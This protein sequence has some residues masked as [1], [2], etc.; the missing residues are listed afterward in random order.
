M[1]SII[2]LKSTVRVE[3]K[4]FSKNL[5]EA[6]ISILREKYERKVDKD[7][8]IVL[9][10]WNP[11]DISEGKVIP[12][13]G[14]SYHE[15]TFDML[16]YK[17][18]LNEIFE[19]EVTEIVEFGVFVRMGPIDGLAHLSQ[20]TNDFLSYDKKI[21]AFIGRESKKIIKKGDDV[22]AKISTV[23]MK[24]SIPETKIGL[25]MRPEGLGKLDWIKEEA[26]PKKIKEEAAP[27]KK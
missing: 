14:A 6:I 20:I 21:P 5:K 4:Y 12:G 2:T 18:E 22:L 26:A 16:T 10:I 11:R 19:G 24:G 8:G 27:K 15:M 17:P 9:C 3:P 23:S 13:D 25:T 7:F 1:Y